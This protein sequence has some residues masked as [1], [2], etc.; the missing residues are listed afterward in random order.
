MIDDIWSGPG[1][2]TPTVLG[3]VVLYAGALTMVRI[4]G[5]RTLAQFSAFDVLVTIAIGSVVAGAALPESP[6]PLDGI[7]VVGTFLLLQTLLGALRQ[8]S[9]HAR[10]YLDFQ[11][12]AVVEQG[13]VSASTSLLGAQLTRAE[14][15]SRL[16]QEG[17]NE[18]RGVA[19]VILEPTGKF[20][21]WRG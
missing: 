6:R 14:I 13:E 3:T 16:R 11:P 1:S 19:L 15:E 8:K 18:L 10:R 5:R 20:S 4:A 17:I 2:V 21:I 7:V 9:R 12:E